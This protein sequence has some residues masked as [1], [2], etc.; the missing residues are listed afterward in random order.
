MIM[1]LRH[2]AWFYGT[3]FFGRFQK[4]DKFDYYF[5]VSNDVKADDE[6]GLRIKEQAI[7][8]LGALF[9]QTKKAKG[10]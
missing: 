4:N 5:Q 1:L 10:T 8:D 6:E 7:L 2:C 3:S 9:T